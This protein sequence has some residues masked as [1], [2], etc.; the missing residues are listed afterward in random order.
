MFEG[1]GAQ[2]R[3]RGIQGTP[4]PV[5][6]ST[7]LVAKA[8]IEFIDS[9]HSLSN[10]P[11]KSRLIHREQ[12]QSTVEESQAE[13]HCLPELDFSRI[14]SLLQALARADDHLGRRRW[15]WGPQVGHEVRD[16]EIGL[17]AYR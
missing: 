16:S 15:G 4:L 14:H 3:R 6:R 8:V 10:G 9:L 5:E 12:V 13:A 11:V 17:V 2:P 1:Q 7:P